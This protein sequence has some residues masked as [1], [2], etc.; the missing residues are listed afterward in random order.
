MDL[1]GRKRRRVGLSGGPNAR[2]DSFQPRRQDVSQ[3]LRLRIFLSFCT[4]VKLPPLSFPL[5][6]ING[7][8]IYP[9]HVFWLL[10]AL[11]ASKYLRRGCRDGRFS[12]GSLILG[13]TNELFMRVPRS[14]GSSVPPCRSQA[15]NSNI[16][17]LGMLLTFGCSLSPFESDYTITGRPVMDMC[18][19]RTVLMRSSSKETGDH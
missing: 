7:N 12:R 16:P 3:H 4:F 19:T 1:E 14:P 13:A 5:L 18:Y 6:Y 17:E 2:V 8:I 15:T 11:N 9:H 10:A